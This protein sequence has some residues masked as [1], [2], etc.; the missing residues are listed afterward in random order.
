MDNGIPVAI[1]ANENI[2]EAITINPVEYND[3]E[4]IIDNVGVVIAELAI[5]IGDDTGILIT[6]AIEVEDYN[7]EYVSIKTLYD[8]FFNMF[9][10]KSQRNKLE[11]V[12]NHIVMDN[13]V[14]NMIE[15][16]EL[17]FKETKID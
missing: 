6:D 2:N 4:V 1:L 11:N 3:S 9:I 5:D 13:T 14:L 7:N 10:A 17:F 15:K 12:I 8:Y 16:E